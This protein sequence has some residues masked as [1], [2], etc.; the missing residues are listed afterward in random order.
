MNRTAKGCG[1]GEHLLLCQAVFDAA[2]EGLAVGE[3]GQAITQQSPL[4]GAEAFG[5]I[6]DLVAARA[7]SNVAL[8]SPLPTLRAAV[9]SALRSRATTERTM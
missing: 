4:H 5:Q 3:T 9:A 1:S 7:T 8:R 6:A 2:Q